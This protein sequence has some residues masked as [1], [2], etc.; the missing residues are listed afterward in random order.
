M[1][2]LLH[3]V[4]R[5]SDTWSRSFAARKMSPSVC[6][7]A[8]LRLPVSGSNPCAGPSRFTGALRVK[9]EIS[10]AGTL[11]LVTLGPAPIAGQ[12]ASAVRIALQIEQNT[13]DDRGVGEIREYA[14]DAKPEELQ[15]LIDW[16]TAVFGNQAPLLVAKGPGVHAQA[17]FMRALVRR[18][19]KDQTLVS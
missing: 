2:E 13:G 14:V 6:A 9:R 10:V 4:S 7:G 11:R 5:L 17:G 19:S 15:V 1:T 8:Y 16:I 12:A 3:A 18:D